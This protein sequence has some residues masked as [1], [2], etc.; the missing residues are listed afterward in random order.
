M[1]ASLHP[2]PSSKQP[3]T[4]IASLIGQFT[5]LTILCS[6][7]FSQMA[8][9]HLRH[10]GI[11]SASV[12][13]IYF[14]KDAV[15][16]PAE[17][18]IAPALAQSHVAPEMPAAAKPAA[19]TDADSHPDT[20]STDEAGNTG[21]GGAEGEGS[22]WELDAMPKSFTM[23]NHEVNIALPIFTPD[24]PIL[25]GEVPALSRGKDLVLNVVINDQGAIVEVEVVQ[26]VDYSVEYSIVQTLRRW[27][28]APA[29]VNGVAIASQRQLRFH[30]PG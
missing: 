28:F 21:E 27:V 3:L 24:P 17:P 13:P 10:G 12:T 4:C 19:A 26:E 2:D 20:A 16:A 25:H 11:H 30:M 23:M 6:I 29:K 1:F 18:E 8:G 22:T 14:H 9:S 5:V 15:A 7:P